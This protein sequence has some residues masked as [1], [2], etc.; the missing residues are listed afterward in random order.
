MMKIAAS[1]VT[2]PLLVK[3]GSYDDTK[4]MDLTVPDLKAASKACLGY[5]EDDALGA[6]DWR[7]GEVIQE[8]TGLCVAVVS[9][10]GLV[11]SVSG[12]NPEGDALPEL[13]L[14]YDLRA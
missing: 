2:G 1:T 8:S 7:G 13:E 9:Y 10:N 12:R 11:F 14:E 3:V 4:L 5:I 6:S